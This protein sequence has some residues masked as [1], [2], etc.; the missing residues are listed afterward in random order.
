MKSRLSTQ[1]LTRMALLI[2]LTIIAERLLSIR[3]P[4]GGTEGFRLGVGPLPVVFSGIFMGPL[5]GGLVGAIADLVGFFINPMGPYMPHFTA[6]SA[7]RGIIPGLVIL[8]AG[9]G[10]REVGVF[11][12]F[13]A[14][15]SMFVLVN[16]LLLPYF[17][18][19][20]F[21]LMRVVVVPTKIGEAAFGIPIYTITLF[22]LGKVMQKVFVSSSGK[23]ALHLSGRLW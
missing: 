12:L 4:L 2:A 13:L 7:L 17:Q 10:R 6:T 8:L 23:E 14:V 19:T 20:L 9:R 18:E 11:P 21:G 22:T 1:M 15:T 16:I 5:A 3:I